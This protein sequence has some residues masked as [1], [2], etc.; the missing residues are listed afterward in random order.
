MK[1]TL[2]LRTIIAAL[3]LAMAPLV[4]QADLLFSDNFSSGSTINQAPGTPTGTS[5]DYQSAFGITNASATIG[6]D[7]LALTLTTSSALGEAFALFTNSPV[8]LSAIGDYVSIDVVFTNTINILASSNNANASLNIGLFNSGGVPPNQGNIVTGAGSVTGGTEDWLGYACRIFHSGNSTIFTRPAQEPTSTSQCQDLL[9]T[10]AS[11]SQAY[12]NP[13]GTSLGSTATAV[14]L[15]EGATY[16]LHFS[17]TL[18]NVG[19]Y[20]ITN[21]LYSGAGTGGSVV[22]TQTKIASGGN[23]LTTGFDGMAIGWRNTS[24]ASQDSSMIISS[25]QING[26]SSG[27]Q[28]PIISSQPAPVAVA[29]NATCAF[30]VSGTGTGLQYQWKRNGTNLLDNANISGATTPSLIINAAGPADELSAANGYYVTISNLAGTTNSVTNSLTLRPATNLVWNGSLGNNTWDVNNSVDWLNPSNQSTVFNYGDP[31]TLDDTAGLK[32]VAL[33][34]AYLSAASV[35][36]NA[37]ASYAIQ[38]SG[39]IAGSA[40]LNYIGSGQL[41]INCAN[42]HTG[43]TVISNSSAYLA[44]QN[45][46]G[47]GNGPLSLYAGFMEVVPV[48]AASSGIVGNVNVADNFTIQFDGNGAFSGVFLGNLA[49]TTGKTLTLM[50]QNDGTTNRFRVYGTNTVMDANIAL[51]GTSTSQANYFG[52]VLAPYHSR[53]TQIYNGVISGNGGLVQRDSGT[54]VLNAQ[55]T[56]SGGTWPTTTGPIAFGVNTVGSVTSGPIGTGPLYLAPELPNPTG[57]GQVM[58]WGGSRTIANPLQY[59]SATNNLT[60]IIGGDNALDFTGPITLNGNDGIGNLSNRVFQV[61]NTAL[62]TFSG[63]MSDG[64]GAFAITKT[65]NGVLALNNAETYTGPTTVSNGTLQVNGSLDAS[66]AVV[67]ATN[68]TLA[69]T[70]TINGTVAIQQG[71]VL[72]PGNSVGTLVISNNLTVNGNL[73]FELNKGANPSND[74]CRVTGA[75]VNTGTGTLTVTNYGSALATGDKFYLFNKGMSGGGTITIVGGGVG[76]TWNN[77]LATEGSISV[78]STTVPKPL[79]SDVTLSGTNLVCTVTNGSVGASYRIL[80]SVNPAAPLSTWTP[81]ATNTF[82]TSGNFTVTI[83]ILPGFPNRCYLLSIP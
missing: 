68:A 48:G 71:G 46:N 82:S 5:T 81:I 83:P 11:S 30:F 70:G 80:A 64:G 47:L 39:S 40:T 49:G 44:L 45:W 77:N 50:P 38:G 36:V 58:A 2:G 60:L 42:I 57:S 65:G 66:S 37:T 53:G 72:A 78:A 8:S 35:T 73:F 29:T 15:D 4:S 67:V 23:F 7:G 61:T 32:V 6:T 59:P 63:V 74:V 17:I 55:N 76:V 21:T 16:T 69:G 25:I 9:F 56:Y 26:F 79:I 43:G 12:N 54:T 13:A 41:T 31:V 19:V 51:V 18:T 22:F 24:G 52:T 28:P 27:V 62:T 1:K 75:L 20:S 34:G 33:G 3:V 14:S 10:G